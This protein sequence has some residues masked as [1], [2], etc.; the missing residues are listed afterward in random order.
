[1]KM[2]KKISKVTIGI[3]SIIALLAIYFVVNQL[4]A[5]D[6]E[7]IMKNNIP[8]NERIIEKEIRNSL[9][10]PY[11]YGYFV[12]ESNDPLL[13]NHTEEYNIVINKYTNKIVLGSKTG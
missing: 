1:M 10:L 4:V 8:T 6:D 12:T 5:L 3:L 7:S 13:G 2:K 11:S 9:V